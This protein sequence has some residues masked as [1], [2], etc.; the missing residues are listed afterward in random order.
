M[1]PVEIKKDIY[2]VGAVDWDIRDFHGYSTYKGS[3]YNAYLAKDEKVALFDTVKKPFYMD[4]MHRIHNLMDPQEIDYLVVNHLEMDHSSSLPQVVEAVKPSKIYTSKMGAKSM[5]AHYKIDNW[6]V[7]AVGTG[8]TLSLGARNIHFLETRM[9]HWP[10]SMFSYIPEEKLLISNDG[11]GQHWAT[12]ERFDDEVDNEELMRQAAKY[13]ANILLLYSPLIQKLIKSVGEM[14]LEI[15]M[16]A[17]DHGLIWRGNPGQILKAYDTW[18]QQKTTAKALV[19]YSTMWHSTEMMA[20]A[21]YDGLLDQGLSVQLLNL[22]KVHRSEVMT[23]VLDANAL[24]FGS[25]TLNNGMMPNMADLLHYMKGLKPTGKICGTF[26][27]YGWS[28]EASKLIAAELEAMKLELVGDPVRVNW[29]PN[30]DTLKPCRELGTKI[31]RMVVEQNLP[32]SCRAIYC[33]D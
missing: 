11:F 21:V 28:G 4:L 1:K 6:P 12:S 25:A 7:E 32:A 27:S 17:P 22:E 24:V 20:K 30:H 14:G 23:E 26:G 31:G 9:V 29:V 5:A 15:D 8:D 18:S 19:I 3:S 13:Y 2:W 10:D 33:G 16:I